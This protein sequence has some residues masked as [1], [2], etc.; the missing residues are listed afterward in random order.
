MFALLASAESL[1]ALISSVAW[2]KLY[3]LTIDSNLSPGTVYKIMAG[4]IM[5]NLPPLMYVQ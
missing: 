1:F 3:N 2:P 5:I 4:V